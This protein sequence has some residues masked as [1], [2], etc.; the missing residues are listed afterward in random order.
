MKVLQINTVC[1]RGSTGRIATDLLSCL[2][3]K[4]DYGEIAY[5]VGTMLNATPEETYRVD[6]KFEYC[7]HNILSRI[8]DNEGCYS[9]YAT[10]RLIKKIEDYRPDVIHLHNIHGHYL[11]YEKLFTF[12]KNS[13]I[14]V[15][16]T[17]HDCWP[18]TG[19]C[20]HFINIGCDQ[21]KKQCTSCSQLLCYPSCYTK[22]N[23]KKNY[24]RKKKSFMGL[25]NLVIVTPSEW[26]AG[27]VKE[28]F[29][30]DYPIKVINNGIS[31]SKFQP[32][33]RALFRNRYALKNET[34]ILGV[35]SEWSTKKGFDDFIHLSR[36]L[37]DNQRIVMVGVSSEQAKNLP[38]SIIAIQRTD[39]A[40]EL[41]E[42]Y[43]AA[44]VFFNFTYEDN[45]PTV[46]LEA[47][48]CGTP[49]VTYRT[50]GSPESVTPETGV[51][52]E[53]G[54]YFDA[55]KL[56]DAVKK[57]D[58]G[59]IRKKACERYEASEKYDEYFSLYKSML[60]NI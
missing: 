48:A 40:E 24:L 28:S 51:V 22:G 57:L 47:L 9:S 13:K 7:V 8:T 10:A 33:E 42:I 11:N 19:H 25:K 37:S 43:S 41:A 58:R 45:F 29:L 50:G 30:K 1:G 34:I 35:A 12:L 54:N 38:A 31:M 36:N 59:V 5:G 46:N 3:R 15:V 53:Q 26:M 52:V 55:L 23:V 14:P 18:I 56:I 16:W 60:S 2:K 4:G 17:F 27:L 49:V 20:T 21:W 44:D 32:K 39:S 6:T